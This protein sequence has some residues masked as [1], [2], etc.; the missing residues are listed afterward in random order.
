MLRDTQHWDRYLAGTEQLV[1][2]KARN[3]APM[4]HVCKQHTER[5]SSI[6]TTDM[7]GLAAIQNAAIGE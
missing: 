2:E 6:D 3:M 5:F 7:S 4:K 1:Y